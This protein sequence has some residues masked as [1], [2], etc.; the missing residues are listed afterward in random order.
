MAVGRYLMDPVVALVTA[1]TGAAVGFVGDVV[2]SS[3]NGGAGVVPWVSEAGSGVAV[4]GLLAVLRLLLK[5]D[6]VARPVAEIEAKLIRLVEHGHEREEGYES[7]MKRLQRMPI[8]PKR[9]RG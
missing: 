1:T 6:L 2:A 8:T 7:T 9:S 4:A 5:G 3:H